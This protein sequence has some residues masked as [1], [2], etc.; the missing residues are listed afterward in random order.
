MDMS[1]PDEAWG[2]YH[3]LHSLALAQSTAK[4]NCR[5]FANSPENC[6]LMASVVPNNRPPASEGTGLSK[7]ATAFLRDVMP[8]VRKNPIAFRAFATNDYFSFGWSGNAASAQEAEA[9]AVDY[10]ATS[11]KSTMMHYSEDRRSQ[12]IDPDRNICRVR[13][14]LSP[15]N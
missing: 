5:H 13:F 15:A 10:C 2:S 3:S 6:R 8:K 12:T 9:K 14:V 1:G 7:D 11:A 4:K